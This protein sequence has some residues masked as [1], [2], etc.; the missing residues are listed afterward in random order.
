MCQKDH[1]EERKMPGMHLSLLF[2]YAA[3]I[4]VSSFIMP[5]K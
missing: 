5:G 3:F 1:E 2:I 4:I